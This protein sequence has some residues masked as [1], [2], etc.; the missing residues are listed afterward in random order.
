VTEAEWLACEDPDRMLTRLPV[1]RYATERRFRL[2]ACAC[3]RRVWEH[4]DDTS[5]SVVE[6]AERYADG[7]ATD[8][9]LN[10]AVALPFPAGRSDRDYRAAAASAARE[11]VWQIPDVEFRSHFAER[12]ARSSCDAVA[13]SAVRDPQKRGG[14]ARGRAVRRTAEA[15]EQTHLIRDIFGPKPLKPLT[16]N[17]ACRTDTAV[18]LARGMYDSR[19]FGAMPILADA[20]QDAGCEDEQVLTHC[21][22][23]HQ[24]HVRGCW[25]C[26]LVLG[27]D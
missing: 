14:S 21:R 22:D 11:L 25:V 17:P 4:L 1:A 3:V 19:E 24:V 6:L 18:S 9:E 2:F 13:W 5:R 16:L 15:R 12:A 26:D 23:A 27:K 20:L 7:H 8:A 10:T